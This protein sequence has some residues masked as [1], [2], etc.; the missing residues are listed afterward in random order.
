MSKDEFGEPWTTVGSKPVSST[1]SRSLLQFL[2]GV[3]AM[4]SL[5]DG[6]EHVSQIKPFVFS[7]SCFWD[8]RAGPLVF[9]VVLGIMMLRLL[10]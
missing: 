3:S 10:Q 4:A 7:L 8:A 1:P 2:L 6:L 5:D 9:L